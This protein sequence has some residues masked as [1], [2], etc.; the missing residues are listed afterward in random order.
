MMGG[1]LCKL[2][3][4]LIADDAADTIRRYLWGQSTF[5]YPFIYVSFR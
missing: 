3:G 1:G 2:V 5:I 4:F